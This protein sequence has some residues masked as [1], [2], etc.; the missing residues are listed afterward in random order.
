[1]NILVCMGI[2]PAGERRV[3][4]GGRVHVARLNV[5]SCRCL[6]M[7]TGTVA[8]LEKVDSGAW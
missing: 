7:L 6:S 2:I 5:C 4:G 8:I 3:G 1:M